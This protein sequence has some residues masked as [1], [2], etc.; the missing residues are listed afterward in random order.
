MP[1]SSGSA[2]QGAAPGQDAETET[3]IWAEE[4][5]RQAHFQSTTALLPTGRRSG[6]PGKGHRQAQR[7]AAAEP[8]PCGSS[9]R[10]QSV[11]QI[12]KTALTRILNRQETNLTSKE[13]Q[14]PLLNPPLATGACRNQFALWR[15]L[16][17]ADLWETCHTQFLINLHSPD[18]T[19]THSTPGRMWT[20]G[21]LVSCAGRGESLPRAE[22]GGAWASPPG[23]GWGHLNHFCS[24]PWAK[25][26]AQPASDSFCSPPPRPPLTCSVRL[27][28]KPDGADW[29]LRPSEQGSVPGVLQSRLPNPGQA[30]CRLHK[31]YPLNPENCAETSSPRATSQTHTRTQATADNVEPPKPILSGK[32][33]AAS[34]IL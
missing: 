33:V 26:P 11:W 32:N 22:G 15:V 34:S 27:P 30:V 1:P 23:A 8:H 7:E 10:E 31:C 18:L 13:K 12:P 28:H 3:Q 9:G 17:N 19:G 16:L 14:Q 5:W 6:D 25:I 24:S 2:C 4:R 29:R 20:P 21:E